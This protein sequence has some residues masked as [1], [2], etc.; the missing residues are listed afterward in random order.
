MAVLS[1][2]LCGM[3]ATKFRSERE[4]PVTNFDVI[5]GRIAGQNT[6]GTQT[7]YLMD[8]LG[9]V[10]ATV[11][12]TCAVKNTYRYK[13]YG[14]VYAKTGTDPDPTFLWNGSTQSRRTGLAYSEQDNVARKYA[15]GPGVWTSVD[16]LWPLQSPYG[17][18]NGNPTTYTDPLGTD[19]LI[20]GLS[21]AAIAF[22]ALALGLTVLYMLWLLERY[23]ELRRALADGID[24]AIRWLR[25]SR[26]GGRYPTTDLRPF[27]STPRP[28]RPIGRPGRPVGR[29][30]RP[31]NRPGRPT[32]KP[33][34]PSN[35][36]RDPGRI[37]TPDRV[38]LPIPFC[39][40][41]GDRDRENCS[42]EMERELSEKMHRL[43]DDPLRRYSCNSPYPLFFPEDSKAI[44]RIINNI[45]RCIAARE[46]RDNR[47]W[48]GGNQV[49]QDEV[50]ARRR[51]LRNCLNKLPR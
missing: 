46:D 14:D 28:G 41:P 45:K 40:Q 23:P 44:Q 6:G 5:N 4:M 10:T 11:D 31:S 13:P 19:V 43:C 17:Y 18:V 50:E 34:K 38:P 42:D 36:S 20:F 37:P 35:P 24:D 49:H 26:E 25:E 47:C 12:S 33:V 9:S 21:L 51:A 39:P 8:A 22:V 48:N 3:A 30:G 7:D 29:P 16:P 1:L 15:T 2:R 32:G 27:P